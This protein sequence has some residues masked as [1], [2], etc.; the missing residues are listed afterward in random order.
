MF[1]NLNNQD[2]DK[3]LK[4]MSISAS[5][6]AGLFIFV[7]I[8]SDHTLN[9]SSYYLGI[10]FL[11]VLLIL[12][13]MLNYFRD[14]IRRKLPKTKFQSQLEELSVQDDSS[15]IKSKDISNSI[16][17]SKPN[18]SFDNIAGMS[19]IKQELLEIVDFLNHPKKYKKYGVSLPKGVL[20]VGPPGVGKTLLAKAVASE[21]NVPFFY[22]SASSFV[23]IYV[24]AGAKK[25]RE[26]FTQAKAVAPAIIF[27]DEIDAIGKQRG[28]SNDERESTLNELL[29]AMDGYDSS[30]GVIVIAATN[31]IEV[32][33]DA[34]LRA[35]RFDR[36]VFLSLPSKEDR[37]AILKLYLKNIKHTVDIEQLCSSTSGFSS[38]AL[39]TL[40]NEALLYMIKCDEKILTQ[41][42]IEYAK[43]KIQFGKYQIK[44]LDNQNKEILAT[45][46]AAKAF[47]S[48]SKVTLLDG[49]VDKEDMIYPSKSYLEQQIKNYLCGSIAL[50]IVKG[51]SY[52][53]DIEDIK[54]AYNLVDDM[55][56]LYKFETSKENLIVK[57]KDEITKDISSNQDKI[58]ELKDIL[59]K[60]EVVVF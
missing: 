44:V 51:D 7:M 8:K 50:E 45:Y 30:S 16:E 22:Q 55:V 27:I 46:Q 6:L 56:D 42:H 33:D 37:E 60:D 52:I 58:D 21:A 48:Q 13:F 15:N 23:N 18:I 53:V 31:K 35:G 40:V 26:L 20:L 17:V 29:S 4:M 41:T 36:R 49:I 43:Q 10:G 1:Q 12:S 25:V 47:I 11:F 39:S 57:L 3:N 24:G 38:S 34:L 5:I 28:S 9:G 32:L 54:K 19:S 59:L 2:R 14:K